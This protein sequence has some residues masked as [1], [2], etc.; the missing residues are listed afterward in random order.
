MNVCG[1]FGHKVK[2]AKGKMYLHINEVKAFDFGNPENYL[3][4]A[5]EITILM[6]KTRNRGIGRGE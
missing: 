2:G 6:Q 1:M 3:A 4:S 5:G